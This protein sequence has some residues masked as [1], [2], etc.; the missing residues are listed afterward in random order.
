MSRAKHE[1]ILEQAAKRREAMRKLRDKKW[2]L[3][4]IAKH[5]D[6]SRQRVCQILGRA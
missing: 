6:I 4:R 1:R 3:E 5:Y 2:T